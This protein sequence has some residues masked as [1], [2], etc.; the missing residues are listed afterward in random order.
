MRCLRRMQSA[1][2]ADSG[3]Q[4]MRK[5]RAAAYI[6][7]AFAV[8]RL[9]ILF[10]QADPLFHPGTAGYFQCADALDRGGLDSYDF[11][12]TPGYPALILLAGFT[13]G[14]VVAAQMAL[15]L[16]TALAVFRIAVRV[17]GRR[18]PSL[19]SAL[20]F[21]GLL[22]VMSFDCSLLPESLSTLLAVLSFAAFQRVSEKP[23]AG[24]MLLLAA[25]TALA[26][27]TRPSLVTLIPSF[28]VLILFA[29][30]PDHR[31]SRGSLFGSGLFASLAMLPIL[32]WML[33]VKGRTSE[34]A[35]AL[36]DPGPG[37]GP[38]ESVISW[39]GNWMVS[40]PSPAFLAGLQGRADTWAAAWEVQKFILALLTLAFLLWAVLPMAWKRLRPVSRSLVPFFA[41][42]LPYSM[43][44]AAVE[45]A[46][47]R[48]MMPMTPLIIVAALGA[49]WRL[50]AGQP[51]DVRE[52]R[53]YWGGEIR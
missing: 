25:V 24:R 22:N 3:I 38:G 33:V 47:R 4:R 8:T 11:K 52:G 30:E 50:A 23:D 14:R 32:A 16:I 48:C 2:R 51:V 18:A 27:L 35:I 10:L 13:P 46:D 43:L 6:V 37:H 20:L 44:A 7:L 49:V 17:T 19:A 40:D 26:V 1:E 53:P 41:V 21:S 34:F 39:I 12:F 45:S 5:L 31:I 9:S 42:A 29:R 28:A 36:A 15:S